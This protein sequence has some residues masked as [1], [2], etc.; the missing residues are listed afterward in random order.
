MKTAHV[1]DRKCGSKWIEI[2][3][4]RNEWYRLK[5]AYTVVVENG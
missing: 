4:D 5:E 3:Q 1:D 2:A